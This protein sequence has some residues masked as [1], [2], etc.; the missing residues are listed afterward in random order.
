MIWLKG[1]LDWIVVDK[2]QEGGLDEEFKGELDEE[3]KDFMTA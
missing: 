2:D 1:V 3:E